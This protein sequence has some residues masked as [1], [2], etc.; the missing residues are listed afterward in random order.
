MIQLPEKT[1]RTL[2]RLVNGLQ[3]RVNVYGIGVFGS[4][5]RGDA[6]TSSDVDLFILNRSDLAFEYVERSE[7][8]G[9]FFDLDFVPRNWFHGQM[10][11]ETDQ[12]L[13]EMQILY[14][15]DWVLTNTKL[16][17]M[18]SYGSPE[19]IS[20]RT[21]DHLL[22]SD[23]YL[24]RA[25]S[26]LSR[27]DHLSAYV[28][29]IV[30]LESML[31][32][33]AEITL[34]P[35]SNTHFIERMKHAAAALE[36]QEAFQEYLEISRLN[37]VDSLG[38]RR[39]LGLFKAA[40]E[41]ISLAARKSFQKAAS[42]HP[43]VRAD[44]NYYLN[45]AFLKGVIMR[46]NSLIDSG[47]NIEASHYLRTIFLDVLQ[48]YLWLASSS[49]NVRIDYTTPINSLGR[50][51]AKNPKNHT[52]IIEFLDLSDIGKVEATHAITEAREIGLQIRRNRKVLIKK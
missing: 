36:M 34:E 19:R 41:E 29:A 52:Q 2:E 5:S 30:S 25:T 4:C 35:F 42:L 26:A 13:Y 43:K 22:N 44:L 28:F 45:A 51:E 46:T 3:C 14:D 7:A 11:P 47:E 1:R 40:W 37:K 31:R 8:N 10:P 38:T 24:S 23:I 6:A 12:K 21:E 18:K 48:N 50:L 20:I 32:I 17:M 33:L 9:V 49:E 27:G 15:R 16:L 39:K